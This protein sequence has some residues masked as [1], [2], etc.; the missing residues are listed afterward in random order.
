MTTA[1]P[2]VGTSVLKDIINPQFHQNSFPAES[3]IKAD[4]GIKLDKGSSFP[5]L[6]V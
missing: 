3:Y 5:Y 6:H 4:L 1:N 2:L